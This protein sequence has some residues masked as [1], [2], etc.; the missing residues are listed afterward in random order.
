MNS[1]LS[2]ILDGLTFKDLAGQRHPRKYVIPTGV[3]VLILALLGLWVAL[4]RKSML[5]A[6]QSTPIPVVFS[7]EPTAS[8]QPTTVTTDQCPTNPAAWTFQDILPADNF[9]RIEPTCVYEGLGKSAAWAL[10]VRS[11][12]TRAEAAQ[13]LSF[14]ALPMRSLSEV[15][16]MTSTKGPLAMKVAFS[17]PHPDFAEWRVDESGKP[18]LAYTLRGCFR[19]YQVVGNQAKSWNADYP[20]ICALSEDFS[21]SKIVFQLD[22]HIF[23]SP[24]EPSRSFVLFG[25]G[26]DGNW[27]WLGTQIEPKVALGNMPN[28]LEEARL[29]AELHELRVWDA[30]WASEKYGLS[31]KALP[32]G[33]Q[34]Q[35][36]ESDKQA[37][38]DGLNEFLKRS[39]P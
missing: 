32:E 12:Y 11:G 35:N 13:A 19:T 18:A 7:L 8:A 23:T 31:V 15:T 3:I 28:F 10:A 24:A 17:P 1:L 39:Q 9:K 16:T 2:T 4:E 37:I 36:N 5:Q 27:V 30:A 20:V 25:Y 14:A 22:D 21:G 26:G 6:V 38:L 34:S 33:W 29:S